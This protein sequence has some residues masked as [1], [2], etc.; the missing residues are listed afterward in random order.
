MKLCHHT[1]FGINVR[2]HF[3]T[4]VYRSL[5]TTVWLRSKAWIVSKTC[6]ELLTAFSSCLENFF[7]Q[8]S[9]YIP[10]ILGTFGYFW[11]FLGIIGFWT[12]K[13]STTCRNVCVL[14]KK[15]WVNVVMVWL[16]LKPW[17]RLILMDLFTVIT[18]AYYG[19]MLKMPYKSC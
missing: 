4:F 14:S 10:R 19:F 18:W 8:W 5:Q 9:S 6:Y 3:Q 1:Y 16:R 11:V 15:C 17:F 2:N 7:F 12:C 13:D